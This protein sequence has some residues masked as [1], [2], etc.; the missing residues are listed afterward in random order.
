MIELSF[1]QGHGS[2][3]KLQREPTH[4]EKI[5]QLVSHVQSKV[6]VKKA[7]PEAEEN[8]YD[9]ETKL[10]KEK[11]RQLVSHVQKSTDK[12][13]EKAPPEDEDKHDENKLTEDEYSKLPEPE[14]SRIFEK[15]L[16]LSLI[17][18]DT[19]KKGYFYIQLKVCIFR[20]IFDNV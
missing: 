15:Q 9:S 6:E 4:Q 3:P 1:F 13:N 5:R 17:S 20:S 10:S 16:A 8:V 2:S 12:K 7:L 18:K 11:I 19:K 14:A